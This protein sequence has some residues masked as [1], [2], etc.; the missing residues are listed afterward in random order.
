MLAADPTAA[1]V[2][3]SVISVATP[4]T[5]LGLGNAG[6]S[7]RSNTAVALV[8]GS[9]S[10]SELTLDGTATLTGG[11][12]AIEA[13]ADVEVTGSAVTVDGRLTTVVRSNAAVV[14][15]DAAGPLPLAIAI[16]KLAKLP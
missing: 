5:Q 13:A 12:V 8:A 16:A 10:G 9:G 14:L 11:R 15:A 3:A 1:S 6:A 2:L 7:I 4:G